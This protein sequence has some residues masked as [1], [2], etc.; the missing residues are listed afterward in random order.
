[1]PQ[2]YKS[3]L[4]GHL[5]AELL[6]DAVKAEEP[7]CIRE[8]VSYRPHEHLSRKKT[9]SHAVAAIA[10]CKQLPRIPPVCTDVRKTILGCREQ[11]IPRVIDR[12]GCH[13]G[14]Q[15]NKI[16]FQVCRLSREECRSRT[17]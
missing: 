2:P 14:I 4:F 10:E 12:G 6:P 15:A 11:T 7:V 13:G 8:C 5:L 17:L 16:L 1:M 9:E 3:S